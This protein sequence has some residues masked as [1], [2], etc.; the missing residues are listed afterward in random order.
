M[1]VL[2]GDLRFEVTLSCVR[3]RRSG[4]ACFS[5]GAKRKLR[6]RQQSPVIKPGRY[7]SCVVDEQTVMCA[8]K[9]RFM[10]EGEQAV[11][12]RSE[13]KKGEEARTA[14]NGRDEKEGKGRERKTKAA[15][16]GS[17]SFVPVCQRPALPYPCRCRFRCGCRAA[18]PGG[19][20]PSPACP[21]RSTTQSAWLLQPTPST[22]NDGAPVLYPPRPTGYVSL[23]IT[24][25]LPVMSFRGWRVWSTY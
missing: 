17:R 10:S 20:H 15:R 1:D 12:Q 9:L 25:M 22:P 7:E 8:L 21:P 4:G 16:E 6:L 19:P 2:N 23:R 14:G 13:E 11:T 24:G 5:R 3:A 18:C